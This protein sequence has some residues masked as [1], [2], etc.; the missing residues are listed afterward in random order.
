L[1]VCEVYLTVRATPENQLVAF[2]LSNRRSG[3]D[4]TSL[5]YFRYL[6]GYRK[7]HDRISPKALQ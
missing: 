1:F 4:V 5:Y 3:V 6:C 7:S 2:E